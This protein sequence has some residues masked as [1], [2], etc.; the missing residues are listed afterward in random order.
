MQQLTVVVVSDDSQPTVVERDA[1]GGPSRRGV[2][3]GIVH[4][5]VILNLAPFPDTLA[6]E[7]EPPRRPQTD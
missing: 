5:R 3:A 1:V 2:P 7:R 4:S 6:T